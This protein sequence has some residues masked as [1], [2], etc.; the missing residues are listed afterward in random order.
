MSAQGRPRA[1]AS[2]SAWLHA[3][4]VVSF[5]L[6]MLIGGFV[7][8]SQHVQEGPLR[9][10]TH[11]VSAVSSRCLN[12]LGFATSGGALGISGETS[13]AIGNECN[14]AWAHLMLVAGI[15][16]FP[17]AGVWRKLVGIVVGSVVVFGVNIVRIVSLYWL[18]QYY[19]MWLRSAHVYIWQFLMIALTL[20]VFAAWTEWER[21]RALARAAATLT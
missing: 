5:A 2:F 6:T 18:A 8:Q 15:A 9:Q 3:R 20:V 11:F 17:A 1:P 14:G 12:V 13:L 16:V 19:P 4:M 7:L 10:F 21:K